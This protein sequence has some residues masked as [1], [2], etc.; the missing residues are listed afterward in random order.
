MLIF[1]VSERRAGKAATQY[2][3]GITNYTRQLC[4]CLADLYTEKIIARFSEGGL[5]RVLQMDVKDG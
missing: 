4:D 1:T 5:E 3:G 2:A